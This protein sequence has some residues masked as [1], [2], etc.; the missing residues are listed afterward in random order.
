MKAE[1]FVRL[2]FDNPDNPLNGVLL[3][4]LHIKYPNGSVLSISPTGE[5]N[6]KYKEPEE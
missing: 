3:C 5:V 4:T 1:D 6:I 2:Q